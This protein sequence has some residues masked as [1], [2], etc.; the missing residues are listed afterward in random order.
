MARGFSHNLARRFVRE[1]AL[2]SKI[3]CTFLLAGLCASPV[4]AD[5]IYRPINPS[6]GGD[7]FNSS[8]LQGLAAT[9]NQFK[10]DTKRKEQTSSERFLNMLESRLY[11]ALATQV[12]DAI[13]G[14]NAQDH[15]TITFDDQTISFTNDGTQIT[16][17]VTDLN[18]GQVTNIVIPALSTD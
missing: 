15:G 10:E 13:F 14:E 6:F 16:L 9:Q 2:F 8:H 11:S 1:I 3:F 17:V 18:T 7:P 5:L 4:A 12:A